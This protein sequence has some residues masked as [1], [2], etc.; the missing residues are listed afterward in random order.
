MLAQEGE[1]ERD[2]FEL[3]TEAQES[4]KW[5][6]SPQAAVQPQP[7]LAGLTSVTRRERRPRPRGFRQQQ[8][9]LRAPLSPK[10]L[11]RPALTLTGQ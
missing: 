11:Q 1:A 5:S 2:P 10:L 3:G 9:T 4:A 7:G 8:R 6:P